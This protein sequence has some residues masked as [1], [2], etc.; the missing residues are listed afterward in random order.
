M[1]II[2]S[3]SLYIK[4]YTIVIK[5]S[6]TLRGMRIIALYYIHTHT[7]TVYNRIPLFIVLKSFMREPDDSLFIILQDFTISTLNGKCR[8]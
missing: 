4:H 5:V 8:Y 7:Q 6:Y 3:A 2:H 1:I